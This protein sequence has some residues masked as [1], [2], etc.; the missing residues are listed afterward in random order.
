MV[1]RRFSPLQ[2]AVAAESPAAACVTPTTRLCT[3]YVLHFAARSW[4]DTNVSTHY[5]L[6]FP[7]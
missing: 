3:V 1:V 4:D 5:N 7:L 2:T 6:Y